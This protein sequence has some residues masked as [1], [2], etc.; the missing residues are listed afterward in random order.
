MWDPNIWTLTTFGQ[1]WTPVNHKEWERRWALVFPHKIFKLFFLSTLPGGT[2]NKHACSEHSLPVFCHTC[3]VISFVYAEKRSGR[4]ENRSHGPASSSSLIPGS[5]KRTIICWFDVLVFYFFFCRQWA[6]WS[7]AVRMYR[8][9]TNVLL[10]TKWEKT[11]DLSTFMW[12]VSPAYTKKSTSSNS[13]FNHFII[14][15]KRAFFAVLVL[16][17]FLANSL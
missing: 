10:R 15:N 17:C 12:P 9:C 6:V 16:L 2:G 7:Y 13:I 3:E 11:R 14:M 8:L 1:H 4:R 5:G